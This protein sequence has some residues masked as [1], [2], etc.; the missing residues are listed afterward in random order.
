MTVLTKDGF[1]VA[2]WPLSCVTVSS[3]ADLLRDLRARLIAGDGFGVATMNLDHVVKLRRSDVFRCAYAAHSHVTADG[4]PIVWLSALA[5]RPV[6]LVTGSDLVAPL[7]GLCAETGTP[8][9]LV[10]ATPDVLERTAER[11]RDMVEGLS[12]AARISP[13]M[14]FDPTG[15]EAD[16]IIGDLGRSGARL[17]LVALGA[18]KQE[19]FAAHAMRSLPQTGFVSVGAGL[20]F[21]A[22]AQ[23]RAPRLVRSLA[24]EW[25]WRLAGDPKRLLGRYAACA[26]VLPS[27]A[28]TALACRLGR[29]ERAGE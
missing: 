23:L 29:A 10:G 2:G 12:I 19:V 20:D 25:A 14:G 13:P 8:V 4:R 21:I 27:L 18:P 22:G 7:A 28:Q 6:E 5:G 3:Q 16:R 15:P 9:A 11:L 26:G 1:E 24:M 17:C